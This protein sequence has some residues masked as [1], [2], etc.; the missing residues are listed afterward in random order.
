MRIGLIPE[1][2]SQLKPG[3]PPVLFVGN[4]GIGKTQA[5]AKGARIADRQLVAVPPLST[6]LP[7][8]AAG[9]PIPH[10]DK[11]TVEFM[12]PDFWKIP[13]NAMLFL[14]ELNLARQDVLCALC[15][16]LWPLADGMR[17]IGS[18][19]VPED[20]VVVSAAMPPS[21]GVTVRQLPH[22]LRS[23]LAIIPVESNLDDWVVWA[24][25]N[26]LDPAV[27]AFVTR[28]PNL[29]APTPPSSQELEAFPTPRAWQAVSDSLIHEALRTELA[30][31]RISGL[32]GPGACNDFMQFKRN[33]SKLPDPLDVITGVEDFPT[34]TSAQIATS[35]AIAEYLLHHGNKEIA[36][37]YLR[38][39]LDWPAEL[40]TAYQFPVFQSA[41]PKWRMEMGLELTQIS[42]SHP[43]W[44]ERFKEL[45]SAVREA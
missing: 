23:R 24:Q 28:N 18:L 43:E 31:Q 10:P 17:K 3:L 13:N 42:V 26:E 4:T 45:F 44:V 40:V 19:N 6:M 1:L 20:T 34:E 21:S 15:S 33:M 30:E 2:V 12:P 16:V 35:A 27:I 32:V 37:I 36:K 29:L 9:I 5:V 8:D 41:T 39:S 7:E 14:D 11:G 22:F 25:M 38:R